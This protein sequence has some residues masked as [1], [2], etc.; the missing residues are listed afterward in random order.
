MAPLHNCILIAI[1]ADEYI[2]N[3]LV[4]MYSIDGV[5]VNSLKRLIR[6][7]TVASW[8]TYCQSF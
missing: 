3:E 6:S 5:W 2:F 1:Q 7:L 8:T 4:G